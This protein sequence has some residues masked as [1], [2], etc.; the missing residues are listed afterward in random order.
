MRADLLQI[1]HNMTVDIDPWLP[2]RQYYI[3]WDCV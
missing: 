3:E 2:I 1:R